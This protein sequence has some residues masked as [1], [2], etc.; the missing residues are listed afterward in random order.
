MRI[1]GACQGQLHINS[2]RSFLYHST[3]NFG[4]EHVVCLLPGI[5]KRLFVGG[6][7]Y[8]SAIIFSISATASVLL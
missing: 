1:K 6:Y 2:G 3:A 5:E 8:S 4:W 7:L